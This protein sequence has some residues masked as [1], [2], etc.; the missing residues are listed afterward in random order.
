M[1]SDVVI[2]ATS[3]FFRARHA[4]RFGFTVEKKRLQA[5]RGVLVYPGL[6]PTYSY[7]KGDLAFPNLS[8]TVSAR[9]RGAELVARKEPIA[10]SATRLAR[11]LRGD[12][13]GASQAQPSDSP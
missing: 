7:T 9:I 11:R 6:V 4:R 3:F 13:R 10:T 5:L 12:G 2:S 1:A 8:H